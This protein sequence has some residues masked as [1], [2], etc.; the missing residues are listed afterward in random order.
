MATVV[1]VMIYSRY[2]VWVSIINDYGQKTRE[3]GEE[4]PCLNTL[5]NNNKSR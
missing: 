2:G 1:M 4:N 5:G 3:F